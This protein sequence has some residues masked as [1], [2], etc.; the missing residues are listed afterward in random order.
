MPDNIHGVV[1]AFH[2]NP[3]DWYIVPFYLSIFF[4]FGAF[5]IYAFLRLT[6]PCF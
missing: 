1:N 5:W 2:L 3:L 4:I 6:S